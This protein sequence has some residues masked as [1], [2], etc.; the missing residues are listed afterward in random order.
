MNHIKIFYEACKMS[1]KKVGMIIDV[2]ELGLIE[3]KYAE[4]FSSYFKKNEEIAK[5]CIIASSIICDNTI[6]CNLVNAFLV[7]YKLDGQQACPLYIDH[8]QE[9][10]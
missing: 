10:I 6:I 5:S 9:I 4:T 1:N 2:R 7:L 3:Y 8:H